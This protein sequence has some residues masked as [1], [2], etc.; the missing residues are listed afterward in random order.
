MLPSPTPA[1]KPE[2]GDLVDEYAAASILGLQVQTLRNWRYLNTGPK[3][4]KIGKRLVRYHLDDLGRFI[5]G[6]DG[7]A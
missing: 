6:I 3:W 7:V 2:P 4:K 1:L 5:N